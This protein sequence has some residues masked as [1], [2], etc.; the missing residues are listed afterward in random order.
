M[1]S[2]TLFVKNQQVIGFECAGHAEY[3]EE[4]SDIVCS[5]V[6]ALTINTVNSLERFTQDTF[7]VEQEEDGGYLK[8]L[9][10]NGISDASALLMNSLSLGLKMIEDTY[11]HA[12]LT[13]R[14]EYVSG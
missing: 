14:E 12:Y 5:A 2:I 6:S 3:A 4:G 13:I 1:I 9:L 7:L 11:G 8:C 10:Q